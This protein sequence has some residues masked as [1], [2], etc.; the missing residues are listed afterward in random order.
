[1]K[2][3]TIAAA[4]VCCLAFGCAKSPT[5][6]DRT[7]A[8]AGTRQALASETT[9]PGQEQGTCPVYGKAVDRSICHTYNGKCV[10]CCSFDCIDAFK[11]RPEE[12]VKKMEKTGIA[13]ED[14]ASCEHLESK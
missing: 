3:R 4:A 12:Y 6:A 14:A 1:M 11:A 13:F 10:Y 7:G 2:H 8:R 9:K 5:R